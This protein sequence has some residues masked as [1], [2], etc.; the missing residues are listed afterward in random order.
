ATQ[1]LEPGATKPSSEGAGL[2]RR[3][4]TLITAITAFTSAIT[5]PLP[6]LQAKAFWP[7]VRWKQKVLQW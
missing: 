3:V 6:Q 1:A 4:A 7:I 2:R 5:A